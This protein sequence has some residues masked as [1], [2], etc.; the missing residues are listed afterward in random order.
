MRE[1]SK[2]SRASKVIDGF[3][4]SCLSDRDRDRGGD[5][6]SLQG[7]GETAEKSVFYRLLKGSIVL[8]SAGPN[9]RLENNPSLF[10][11]YEVHLCLFQVEF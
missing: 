5:L 6:L 2:L 11:I 7:R 1:I 3:D 4:F 9:E 8:L 10:Q